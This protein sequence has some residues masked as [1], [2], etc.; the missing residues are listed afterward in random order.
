M[1]GARRGGP[2]RAAAQGR[3]LRTGMPTG[4]SRVALGGGVGPPASPNG[5]RTA[6]RDPWPRRPRGAPGSSARDRRA[7][8]GEPLDGGDHPLD[9]RLHVDGRARA[10]RSGAP[11]RRG[12]VQPSTA[13]RR[14]SRTRRASSPGSAPLGM[15]TRRHGSGRSAT[16]RRGSAE[17]DRHDLRRREVGPHRGG[18]GITDLREAP[19][20]LPLDERVAELLEVREDGVDHRLG[21]PEFSRDGGH[22][23]RAVAIADDQPHR[24]IQHLITALVRRTVRGAR[25]RVLLLPERFGGGGGAVHGATVLQPRRLA[26]AE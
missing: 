21:E 26:T 15:S 23:G 22:R 12:R 1:R 19:Q 25:R 13:Q 2:V 20:L 11:G 6:R 7:G 18:E 10:S 17:R 5:W 8:L 14:P 9:E 16:L 3:R 4:T 24:S